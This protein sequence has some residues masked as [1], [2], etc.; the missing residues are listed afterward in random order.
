MECPK[1][2]AVNLLFPLPVSAADF[3][4]EKGRFTAVTKGIRYQAYKTNTFGAMPH[5]PCMLYI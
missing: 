4:F 2:H 5:N 3:C 1:F